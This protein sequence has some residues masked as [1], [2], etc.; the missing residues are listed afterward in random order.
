MALE[1]LTI[2]R[3]CLH[4]V[5]KRTDERAVVPPTY[6]TGLLEL[7][8]RART[9]FASR[10]IAAFRSEAQCMWMTI[11]RQTTISKRCLIK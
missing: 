4:E 6:A 9:A 7:D 8:P 10:V 5:Y 11:A 1:N 2:R 3:V